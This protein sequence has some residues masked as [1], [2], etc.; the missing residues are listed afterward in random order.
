M[1]KQSA[2]KNEKVKKFNLLRH[3]FGRA[4]KYSHN[5]PALVVPAIDGCRLLREFDISGLIVIRAVRV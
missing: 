4:E 1:K 5:I 2:V 3:T